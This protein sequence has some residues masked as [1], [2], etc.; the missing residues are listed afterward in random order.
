MDPNILLFMAI[1]DSFHSPAANVLFSVITLGGNLLSWAMVGLVLVIKRKERPAVDLLVAGL[2]LAVV[3]S[4]LKYSIDLPRPFMVIPGIT[5]LTI[6]PMGNETDPGFPSF[7]AAMVTAGA[8]ILYSAYPR[9][10]VPLALLVF[11]VALSRI[12]LG[13]HYPLDVIVGS[14]IGFLVGKIAVMYK[15]DDLLFDRLFRKL[16]L[17]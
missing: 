5:Q 10:K 8:L 6:G 17:V 7:H 16:R 3:V 15:D 11:L 4:A 1:Y 12:Y 13:V 2:I 9:F 14:L